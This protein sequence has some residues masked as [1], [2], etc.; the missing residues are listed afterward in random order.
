MTFDMAT[1]VEAVTSLK[2]AAEVVEKLKGLRGGSADKATE[3]RIS[4]LQRII[5]SAHGSALA[6]QMGQ[7]S[8]VQTVR[9]LEAKIAQFEAWEREKS[10][11]QLTE[12]NT[13]RGDVFLYA[14]KPEA[15][16]G[17]PHHLVCPKCFEHRR[18]SIIQGSPQTKFGLR[19]HLCAECQTEY[20]FSAAPPDRPQSALPRRYNPFDRE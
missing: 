6:A 11:Y 5:L 20:L 12:I 13:G 19:V 10:R 8:L 14:L 1:I 17:E 7:L 9:D 4:E 2:T 16:Q 18:R 15:A 3:E